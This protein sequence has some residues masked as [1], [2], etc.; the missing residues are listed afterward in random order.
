M[1]IS[2]Q[3]GYFSDLSF[4]WLKSA[5]VHSFIKDEESQHIDVDTVYWVAG[6]Q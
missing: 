6:L 3:T 4:E 1:F 2:E 5:W